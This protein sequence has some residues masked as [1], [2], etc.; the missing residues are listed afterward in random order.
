M[1]LNFEWDGHTKKFDSS[2]FVGTSPAFDFAIFSLCSIVLFKTG[3]VGVTDCSCKIHKST[4]TIRAIEKDNKKFPKTGK[5][6]TAFP[7]SVVPDPVCTS[8]LA[9]SR[10]DC[11]WLGIDHQTC[12]ERKCCFDSKKYGSGTYWCFYPSGRQ[13]TFL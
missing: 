11:G 6:C 1:S 7:P 2:M 3:G 13:A 9:T 8:I 10:T 4:V 12:G 5:I